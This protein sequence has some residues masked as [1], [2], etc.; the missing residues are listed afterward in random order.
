MVSSSYQKASVEGLSGALCFSVALMLCHFQFSD[1]RLAPIILYVQKYLGSNWGTIWQL[2][3]QPSLGLFQ[4]YLVWQAGKMSC[5]RPAALWP[6]SPISC[7]TPVAC[8]V[9]LLTRGVTTAWFRKKG[10]VCVKEVS[11]H[12]EIGQNTVD[13]QR[14]LSI[15]LHFAHSFLLPSRRLQL[16]LCPLPLTS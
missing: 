7:S 9:L 11:V 2:S 10:R 15:V 16:T 1:L 5:D 12:R 13:L 14:S 8:P 4:G 3:E 6:V